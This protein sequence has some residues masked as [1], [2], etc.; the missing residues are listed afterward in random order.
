MAEKCIIMKFPTISEKKQICGAGGNH[1]R[2]MLPGIPHLLVQC[3][4]NFRYSVIRH[5][6]GL[7]DKPYLTY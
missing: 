7:E 6:V 5:G 2:I 4:L 1:N 3:L